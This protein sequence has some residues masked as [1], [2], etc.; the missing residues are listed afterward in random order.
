MAAPPIA[1]PPLLEYGIV[2][3]PNYYKA[4]SFLSNI[5]RVADNVKDKEAMDIGRKIIRIARA[6]L[7]GR[8]GTGNLSSTLQVKPQ[9][10]G[11][12][13]TAG[14]MMGTGSPP[15][16]VDYAQYVEF[17]HKSRSGSWVPPHPYLYPAIEAVLN[18]NGVEPPVGP[19]I[20]QD[21]T[22]QANARSIV[23]GTMGVAA[24]GIGLGG[25]LALGA[26]AMTA[27]AGVYSG[28]SDIG[29]GF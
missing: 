19:K 1:T 3:A 25:L 14:G 5:P 15:V 24:S 18:G 26:L 27:F 28:I 20:L 8:G 13:V 10:K 12:M 21:I 29:V 22:R 23:G 7:D 17:G 16:Y 6:D 2:P 11:I 9:T 4:M